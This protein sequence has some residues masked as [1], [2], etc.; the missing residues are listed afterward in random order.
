MNELTENQIKVLIEN[1]NIDYKVDGSTDGIDLGKRRKYFNWLN[2]C[3]FV[4]DNGQIVKL[5]LKENAE[6]QKVFFEAYVAWYDKYGG[7]FMNG[8]ID[9]VLNAIKADVY[10]DNK[11]KCETFRVSIDNLER[12]KMK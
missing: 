9:L 11:D 3:S 8:Y 4:S 2:S 10:W 5:I 1:G 7:F 12:K 6:S